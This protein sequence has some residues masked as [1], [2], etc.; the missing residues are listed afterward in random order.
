MDKISRSK[1]ADSVLSMLATRFPTGD[2]EE[3]WEFIEGIKIAYVSYS[4]GISSDKNTSTSLLAEVSKKF[5][6]DLDKLFLKYVKLM[7][8]RSDEEKCGRENK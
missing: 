2:K 5:S 3:T 7:V 4:L 6:H 8:T 1:V